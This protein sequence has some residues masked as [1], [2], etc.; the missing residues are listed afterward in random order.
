MPYISSEE[1]DRFDHLLDQLPDFDSKGELE[2][3]IFKLM[4]RYASKRELRY[5]QLHDVVYAA[6]HCSDEF[7][8]L[9]L[10]KREE[11]A[12]AENG[13]VEP[14]LA[15]DTSAEKTHH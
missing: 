11:Q 5:S 7:R 10:D 12:I 1:R 2:Y 15:L 4:K 14:L 13:Q 9:Y 3:C 8:R 6:A